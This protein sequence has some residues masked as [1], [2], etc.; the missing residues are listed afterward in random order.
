MEVG[1]GVGVGE[2]VVLGSGAF[3]VVGSGWLLPPPLP[4]AHDHDIWK[5]PLSS[6]AK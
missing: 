4:S 1:V 3:V 5:T 6:D 2:G